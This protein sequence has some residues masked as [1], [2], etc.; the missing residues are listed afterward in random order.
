MP[1]LSSLPFE[2]VEEISCFFK[3]TES[4]RVLTVN[5]VLYEAFVRRIW[6][7]IT[8]SEDAVWKAPPSV[9]VLNGPL[10]R[11][12]SIPSDLRVGT[13][14]PS[15]PNLL[16]LSVRLD[17]V[18]S[19]I[20]EHDMPLLQTVSISFT[21]SI[22][23]ADLLKVAAWVSDTE[24][25]GQDVDI[26][27]GLEAKGRGS[28]SWF[29]VILD[30]ITKPDLHSLNVDL[31]N[32]VFDIDQIS[33]FAPVLVEIK[34]PEM[35]M[36]SKPSSLNTILSQ[37]GAV[38][39]RLRYLD[40]RLR[41]KREVRPFGNDMDEVNHTV[42]DSDMDEDNGTGD[43][44]RD[45]D[46]DMHGDDGHVPSLPASCFPALKS[47]S[48][49]I[50][51]CRSSVPRS[52]MNYP[53]FSKPLSTVTELDLVSCDYDAWTSAAKCVPQLKD[54]AFTCSRLTLST[55]FLAHNL[56][57]L[58][59]LEIGEYCYISIRYDESDSSRVGQLANLRKF[60]LNKEGSG[61]LSPTSDDLKFILRQLPN[62]YTL[63]IASFDHD[64]RV[65]DMLQGETNE[66]VRHLYASV[67]DQFY[68]WDYSELL[69][70]FP[71]LS[72]FQCW[73]LS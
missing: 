36:G 19:R 22:K 69:A 8:P 67:F 16:D 65:F 21:D 2:L 10:V 7:H 6:R 50:L 73:G 55:Q 45:G 71:N 43:D 44:G 57:Q 61:S 59:R 49:H 12:I 56:P 42:D 53:F 66:S 26:E 23:R 11:T 25:R 39:S 47:L 14:M 38:F 72:R 31:T 24:K 68:D 40:L 34:L 28:L 27:Y 5:K 9:W 64:N 63:D 48:I 54:L 20:F 41:G 58:E 18:S 46:N 3:R 51:E 70:L 29:N 32:G 1:S 35:T 33:K 15:L 17:K 62:L 30:V 4:V 60:V 13:K 52:C 37:S